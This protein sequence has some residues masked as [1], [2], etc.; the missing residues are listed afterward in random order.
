MMVH[1][2]QP[3]ITSKPKDDTWTLYLYELLYVV[4][5]QLQLRYV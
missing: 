4:S 5:C 2:R 1:V 3:D